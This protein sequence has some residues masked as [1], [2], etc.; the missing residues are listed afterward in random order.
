MHAAVYIQMLRV[1]RAVS[2]LSDMTGCLRGG[3]TT[4]PTDGWSPR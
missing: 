3:S 2:G 1:S 4:A